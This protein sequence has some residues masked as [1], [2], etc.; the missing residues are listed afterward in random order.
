M[1]SLVI[2]GGRNEGSSF[3]LSEGK[4]VVGR[5]PQCA[6]RLSD[7]WI[8]RNHASISVEGNIFKVEDLQSNNGTKVN[9]AS[10]NSKK[11]SH[12][13]IILFGKTPARFLADE[14]D[15]VTRDLSENVLNSKDTVLRDIRDLQADIS[16]PSQEKV[17]RT[18]VPVVVSPLRRQ[19]KVLNEI[20]KVCTE[21][22]DLE[23]SLK[24]ILDLVIVN[25]NAQRGYIFL[26]DND[27]SLKPFIRRQ[28]DKAVEPPIEVS[29]TILNTSLN[30]RVA[31]LT[32]NAQEDLR[33]KISKSIISHAITSC[34]CVPLW[35]EDRV[36]GLAVFD[37]NMVE[38]TFTEEDLDICT[39]VAYQMAL[40]MEERRLRDQVM[41]EQE[42]R[43]VLLRHFSPDVA[44]LLLS[45]VEEDR[46]PLEIGMKEVTILFA[47]IVGFTTV[48]ENLSPMDMASL[49]N[50]FFK[51]MSEAIFMEE[52]T[53]DKFIGD[54]V[55]A[56]FG[57]PYSHDDDPVR[58]IRCALRMYHGLNEYN[59]NRPN[60]VQLKARIGINTG[61]V[62]S[63]NFGSLQRMEYTVIGDAVNTAARLQ[64]L[65]QPGSIL[66]G[67]NTY[68]KARGRF[69]FRPLGFIPVRGKSKEVEVL[70]VLQSLPEDR[71]NVTQ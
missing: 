14:L 43:N 31:I 13:D 64:S 4:N 22:L 2:T 46:N 11:L 35:L 18:D 47:D 6:I 7:P 15:G 61:L 55:M 58:A 70:E 42:K 28:K 19:L 38:H 12:G 24:S 1:P 65:A 66:I 10:V 27:G 57:A 44:E 62:V 53:L 3:Y 60:G 56:I 16:L 23:T 30:K 8:S 39:A 67:K 32:V 29:R 33:F 54:G 36:L 69:Y 25:V 21:G 9:G 48:S 5:N 59:K 45:S 63:G 68:D 71:T 49:L 50:G 37:S 17:S 26:L 41:E 51:L 20:G 40:A 52:G 34:I